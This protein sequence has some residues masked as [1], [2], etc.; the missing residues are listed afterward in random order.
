[1]GSSVDLEALGIQLASDIRAVA[2]HRGRIETVLQEIEAA[3]EAEGRA[4][5]LELYQALPQVRVLAATYAVPEKRIEEATRDSSLTEDERNDFLQ[6]AGK[7]RRL[8]KTPQRLRDLLPDLLHAEILSRGPLNIVLELEQLD[9]KNVRAKLV[10]EGRVT[11]RTFEFDPIVLKQAELIRQASEE[12][13]PLPPGTVEDLGRHLEARVLGPETLEAIRQAVSDGR[14]VRIF[15]HPSTTALL[16]VP[17]ESLLRGP[18]LAKLLPNVALIRGTPDATAVPLSQPPLPPLRVL[19]I[20]SS[21]LDLDPRREIQVERE[22]EMVMEPLR[23]LIV[24][25]RVRLKVLDIASRR[26]IREALSG[27]HHIVHFIGH[28]MEGGLLIEDERGDGDVIPATDFAAL[29]TEGRPAVIWLTA[30]RSAACPKDDPRGSVA[31]AL[32]SIGVPT[33]VAMG[34]SLTYDAGRRLGKAFYHAL[35]E[36]KRPEEALESA[37]NALFHDDA[38]HVRADWTIPALFSHAPGEAR[39][40]WRQDV[41]PSPREDWLSGLNRLDRGFVGR[42]KAIREIREALTSQENRVVVIQGLPGIGKSVLASRVIEDIRDEFDGVYS[43]TV[44]RDQRSGRSNLDFLGFLRELDYFLRRHNVAALSEAATQEDWPLEQKLQQLHTALQAGRFLIVL[45]GAE[46]LL[47]DSFRFEDRAFE[48]ML[49]RLLATGPLS[50]IVLTTRMGPHFPQEERYADRLLVMPLDAFKNQEARELLRLKDE[51]RQL[52][53]TDLEKMLHRAQGIPLALVSYL[54]L[55]REPGRLREVLASPVQEAPDPAYRAIAEL[56]GKLPDGLRHG[57]ARAVL[58]RGP[59]DRAALRAAGLTSP[60]IDELGDRSLLLH[61]REA[62]LYTMHSHVRVQ[63]AAALTED[64]RKKTHAAIAAYLERFRQK[65]GSEYKE[66]KA[67][68]VRSRVWL[69][70]AT[71]LAPSGSSVD[72]ALEEH[73]HRGAAGDEEGSARLLEEIAEHLFTTGRLTELERLIQETP[74]PILAQKASLRVWQARVWRT[75][76]QLDKA[77]H[78]LE[79]IRSDP[80][81][82]SEVKIGAAF[83][84]ASM[85]GQRGDMR[86]AEASFR[87]LVDAYPDNDRVKSTAYH[88]LGNIQMLRG[89][90]DAALEW[91]QKSLA[92]MERLGNLEGIAGSYHQI[93]MIHQDRGDYDAALEWYQKSLAL[94]ERLGNLAGIAASLGQIGTVLAKQKKFREAIGLTHT[95]LVLF[96]RIGSPKAETARSV[97]G[98]ILREIGEA[99]FKKLLAEVLEQP[100]TQPT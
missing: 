20:L 56:V 4:K 55:I 38:E 99:E 69:S 2:R 29:F 27:N 17:W 3:P 37:R 49:E 23:P 87:D 72:I 8:E 53:P 1:M 71:H 31:E 79:A 67:D 64:E 39:L 57:G 25:G 90:Y 88:N 73:F 9:G 22:R 48:E 78:A 7:L 58:F 63:L 80:T 75:H 28:G 42:R 35:T 62:D 98:D 13:T 46:G 96:K 44:T 19:L 85:A 70:R 52:Q 86:A 54:A 91:Y 30:C 66:A 40:Q 41:Q 97:M 45:D 11:Q 47:D 34:Y 94:R 6:L 61:L 95:A 32:A 92:L 21:P 83:D 33:V 16:P 82:D 43:R 74:E 65:F 26:G 84:I 76:G 81:A 100:P 36:G 24:Q 60:Q 12:Q 59:A 50:R 10:W 93:G 14:R 77:L 51:V 18:D 89:D 68:P 5:L 15:L